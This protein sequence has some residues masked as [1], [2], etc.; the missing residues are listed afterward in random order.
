VLADG[1][2]VAERLDGLPA[3]VV[4]PPGHADPAAARAYAE[5]LAALIAP[6]D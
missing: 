3:Q 4:Q 2:E 6:P 1:P 5:R